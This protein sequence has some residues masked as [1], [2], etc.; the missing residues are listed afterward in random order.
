M[1]S[2]LPKVV[3]EV[4][5]QPMVRWV[6][7]AARELGA[8]PIVLVIG[9]GANEVRRLFAG[10]NDVTFVTQEQ[11]LGTGHA[12]DQARDGF[13]DLNLKHADVFVLAGDGPLIR[14]ATLRALLDRHQTTDAVATL[15]TS[16]IPD[17]TGYGR[18]V[19]DKTDRL[20][21]IVEHKDASP[22]QRQIREVNPSYYCFRAGPLF[23]MLKLVDNKNANGE[24][25]ITDVFTH[26]LASGHRVEVIDAVPPED[27]LSINDPAQLAEVESILHAR[28]NGARRA[29]TKVE[30]AR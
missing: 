25:Y 1:N 5:G 26:L 15:A 28:L 24:Y 12:V 9:H 18:I 27:V 30:V 11:Q 13:Q 21:R 3:H 6:V 16:V 2:D 29:P 19:R 10:D 22:E 14:P 7:D 23:D 8:K 17:P 4:A 20:L